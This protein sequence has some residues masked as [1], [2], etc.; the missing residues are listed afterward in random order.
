MPN[1]CDNTLVV[2]GER[3]KLEEFAQKVTGEETLLDFGAL[4][5][6]P[7]ELAEESGLESAELQ[8]RYGASN[9][10]DWC[11]QNWGTKWNAEY[12]DRVDVGKAFEYRF[13]T[14]WTPPVDWVKR[15]AGIFPELKFTLTWEEPS[16]EQ[17]GTV[18]FGG[19]GAVESSAE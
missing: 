12:W 13:D 9:L 19:G 8:R 4:V 14:A 11:V 2:E 17:A 7:R 15:V 16:Q 5:P 6:V 3:E 10:L 1:W 18:V